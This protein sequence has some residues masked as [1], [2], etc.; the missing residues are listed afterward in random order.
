MERLI[1]CQKGFLD[2]E[3][4]PVSSSNLTPLKPLE[5]MAFDTEGLPNIPPATE[6][7]IRALGQRVGADFYSNGMSGLQY[8]KWTPSD[9]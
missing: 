4:I 8:F 9:N 3:G 7:E 5:L 1:E 2:S 6:K